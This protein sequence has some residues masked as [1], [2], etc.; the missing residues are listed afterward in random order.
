LAKVDCIRVH[1]AISASS[2][3]E[4]ALTKPPGGWPSEVRNEICVGDPGAVDITITAYDAAGRLLGFGTGKSVNN[5][6]VE[7]EL[8]PT[9]A[10][11]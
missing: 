3:R 9:V 10:W 11:S 8:R 7:I 2:S 4:V 5:S 6:A 1:V